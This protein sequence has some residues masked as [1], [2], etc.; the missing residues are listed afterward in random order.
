[1][2]VNI[3]LPQ[4]I[5]WWSIWTFHKFEEAFKMLKWNKDIGQ[6]VFPE[7]LEISNLKYLIKKMLKTT[8][9]FLSKLFECIINNSLY[10][11]FMNKNLLHKNQFGF[12]ISNSTERVA[13]KLTRDIAQNFDNRKFTLGFFNDLSEAFDTVDHQILLKN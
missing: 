4:A 10:E 12:Q 1:M 13:L 8:N 2:L 5:L 9:K 11:Y 7:K 6:A 3:Y